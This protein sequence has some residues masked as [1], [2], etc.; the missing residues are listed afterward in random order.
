V[1]KFNRFLLAS[2][3]VLPLLSTGC[4]SHREVRAWGPG[5][6]TYYVQWEHQTHRNHMDWDR[7]SDSDKNDYWKWRKHHH[8]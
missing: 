4:A 8:D 6:E 7:R 5:E 3:F 1:G 2:V